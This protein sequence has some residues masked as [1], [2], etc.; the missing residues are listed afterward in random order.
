MR[1]RKSLLLLFVSLA[2]FACSTPATRY[3]NEKTNAELAGDR[4]VLQRNWSCAIDK[5]KQSYE[6]AQRFYE[7][8]ESKSTSSYRHDYTYEKLKL[9]FAYLSAI[10]IKQF[11]PP[12]S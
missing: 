7:Y 3:L 10:I 1:A 9:Y 2:L 5:Y 11:R 4:C 8:V 12:N 6:A